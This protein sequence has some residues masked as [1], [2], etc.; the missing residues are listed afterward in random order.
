MKYFV[1][2]LHSSGK[3]EVLDILT[4]YGVKCGKL[5]SNIENPSADIYNSFNYELFTNTDIMEM[6]KIFV[7]FARRSP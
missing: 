1:I 7:R 4:K 2:G 3:Q 6:R 5:F